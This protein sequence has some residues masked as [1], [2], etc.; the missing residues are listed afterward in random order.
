MLLRVIIFAAIGLFILY[1]LRRIWFDWSN[2]F[3]D[4][5]ETARRLRRERDLAE[6]QRPDVIDLKRDND[7]TFRP[8]DKNE[9]H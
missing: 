7:G 5:E 8:R 1:G 4:D 3:K 2:K 6:R 9:R